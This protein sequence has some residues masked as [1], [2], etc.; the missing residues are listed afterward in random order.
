[1]S[2]ERRQ[3]R[4]LHE[5]EQLLF[6]LAIHSASEQVILSYPRSEQNGETAS[7][8]SFYLLRVLE[9]LTGAPAT[10]A[11]LRE[12][13]HRAPLFPVSFG[14][15]SEA[16]R[17]NRVSSPQRRACSRFRDPALL[18]I[19]TDSVAIFCPHF[20]RYAKDGTANTLRLLTV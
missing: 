12:W 18:R 8:P 15:P 10:F 6:V 11:D 9:A 14:P 13:E 3:R 1:L 5:A 19:S 7:T 4:G 17:F 20:R 16:H 2:R